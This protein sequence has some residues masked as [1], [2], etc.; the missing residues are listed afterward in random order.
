L[1]A[2]LKRR[3][4]R[5]VYECA[6]LF[7]GALATIR[8]VQHARIFGPHVIYER[9]SLHLPAGGLAARLLG[10]PL[11][12]EVNAPLAE[13]R[14]C[15]G[16]LALPGVARVSEARTWRT[17]DAVLVVSGPLA[18]RVTAAGVP[19]AK[20]YVVTNGVDPARFAPLRDQGA[21]RAALGIPGRLVVGFTGFMR[22][23][24]GLDRVVDWLGTGAPPWVVLCCV[25]DGPA[26]AGLERRAEERGVRDRLIITGVLPREQVPQWLTAFDVA[27]Q[28]D[29]VS[30]AS[31]LKLL[32]YMAAGRAIVAP[33]RPNIR[34]LLTDGVDALLV[35]PDGLATALDRVLQDNALRR[36]LGAQARETIARRNLTWVGNAARI[37]EIANGL[38]GPVPDPT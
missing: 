22:E 29:V 32:E 8:L 33:D 35:P 11:L 16:G 9:Y 12:M 5:S 37:V 6:E 1:V 27:V 26:R 23:W 10:V 28:P 15:Y 2:S 7:Y 38:L 18:D 24:H 3:L 34:E 14:A 4:P 21:A 20:V 31:P 19:A 17:A 13:E 36:R 30:Y 25:G